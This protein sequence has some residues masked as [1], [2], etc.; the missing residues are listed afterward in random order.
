MESNELVEIKAI[1]SVPKGSSY[2]PTVNDWGLID[3]TNFAMNLEVKIGV[4]VMLIYNVCISDKLVNGQFGQV[5]DILFDTK[6]E[7]EAIIVS[8]DDPE[9]RLRN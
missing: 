8:F 9:A 1:I 3:K 4:R 7:V 6:G 2:K 5:I